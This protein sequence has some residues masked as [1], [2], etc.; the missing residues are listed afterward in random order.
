MKTIF[1]ILSLLLTNPSADIYPMTGEVIAVDYAADVVTI[2]SH[3]NL[4]EFYGTDDWVP[5]D[6]AACIMSDNGTRTIYDDEIIVVRY[7]N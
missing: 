2:E 5:G 3:N 1:V 4:W 6:I 7:Q